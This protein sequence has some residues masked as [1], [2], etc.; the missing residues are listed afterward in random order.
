MKLYNTTTFN[1]GV[2]LSYKTFKDQTPERREHSCS[3]SPDHYW[4]RQAMPFHTK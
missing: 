3:G 1:E 4:W 2:Y